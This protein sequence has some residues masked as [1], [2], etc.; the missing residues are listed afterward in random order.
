MLHSPIR[1]NSDRHN[2]EETGGRSSHASRPSVMVCLSPSP[3][4]KRVIRTAARMVF[5]GPPSAAGSTGGPAPI[6]LYVS[7]TGREAEE[8]SLRVLLLKD[9]MLLSENGRSMSGFAY[10]P[11]VVAK[12]KFSLD[13]FFLYYPLQDRSWREV[14]NQLDSSVTG[15]SKAVFANDDA[16]KIYFSSEDED[17][18]RNIYVTEYQDTIWTCPAL[19][20]EHLISPAEEIYPMVSP[21]GRTLYFA[22]SG[23]YGVGGF[24]IYMSEWSDEDND[25]SVPVNMGFPYSSPADDFLLVNTDD[26]RYTFFAS[27]RECSADYPYWLRKTITDEKNVDVLYGEKIYA[28][29]TTSPDAVDVLF[30]HA[31]AKVTVKVASNVPDEITVNSVTLKSLCTA[32]TV[33]VDYENDVW[34]KTTWARSTPSDYTWYKGSFVLST[35]ADEFGDPI[36]FVP[37]DSDTAVDQTSFEVSYTMNGV[38]MTA[39]VELPDYWEMGKHYIY[40]LNANLNEI[41]FAPE[42]ETLENVEKPYS[43]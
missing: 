3:S 18:I 6:A 43:L 23:L 17:G 19:L 39:Q 9:K 42:V 29:C 11:Y 28:D 34:N 38:D 15:F 37:G 35:T 24:D 36:F 7:T 20:N 32:G 10:S 5:P 14:P 1:H 41:T 12:H 26:S 33:T 2:I 40:T 25:W 30:K 13:D 21:D 31:V 22:S 16:R 4:T 27:N 8:D